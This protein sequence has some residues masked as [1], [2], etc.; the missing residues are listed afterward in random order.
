[1]G[2]HSLG[3]DMDTVYRVGDAT[4]WRE[5][6][7][8]IIV[9]DTVDSVYYAI[10]GF[11]AALWPKLVVGASQENLID[12]IRST[13]SDVPRAQASVDVHDFIESC[14]GNGFIEAVTE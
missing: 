9:L 10:A 8:E 5:L 2:E 3:R 14:L 11:G 13:F 7:G 6:D 1:M 4:T 12:E